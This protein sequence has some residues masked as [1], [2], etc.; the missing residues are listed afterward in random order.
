MFQTFLLKGSAHE[1]ILINFLSPSPTLL[2]HYIIVFSATMFLASSLSVL[3]SPKILTSLALLLSAY[4]LRLFF[5]KRGKEVDD[6]P[7]LGQ[8]GDPDF[9]AALSK[10]Y[11]Q[12]KSLKIS[13]VLNHCS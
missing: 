1:S 13:L 10:G 8:P 7:M 11:E 2:G 9:Q 6:S 12:V 3:E 5:A 4:A